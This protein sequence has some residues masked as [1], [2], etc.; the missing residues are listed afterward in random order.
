MGS[1]RRLIVCLLLAASTAGADRAREQKARALY[2]EGKSA[3]EGGRYGD[4]YERFRQAYLESQ[5]PALLFNMAS[6]LTELDRPGEASRELR[7]YLE[8]VPND[9][10]RAAIELRIRTLDEKQRLIDAR[11]PKPQ[12]AVTTPALVAA[13][14]PEK[15]RSRRGL[16]IGLGVAGAVLVVGAVAVGLGLG[17]SGPEYRASTLGAYPATK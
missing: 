16:A 13:P 5:E 11:A 6:C 12:A 17:L 9:A 14:A 8:L 7:T 3:F 15:P 2:M 10:D 4:A 1:V